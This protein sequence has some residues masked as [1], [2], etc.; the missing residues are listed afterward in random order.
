MYGALWGIL[1]GPWWVRV[2]ILLV[3]FAMVLIACVMWVFPYIDHFVAPT[4][5]TV[6][7]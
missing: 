4:D 5:S 3:V 6:E 7:T 1:P 2:L